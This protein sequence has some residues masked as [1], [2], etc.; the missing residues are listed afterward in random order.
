MLSARVWFCW[1]HTFGI[2]ISNY[3]MKCWKVTTVHSNSILNSSTF[4]NH[5]RCYS[6]TPQPYNTT[7]YNLHKLFPMY[8]SE[9]SPSMISSSQHALSLSDLNF[10]IKSTSSETNMQTKKQKRLASKFSCLSIVTKHTVSLVEEKTPHE[11]KLVPKLSSGEIIIRIS[12]DPIHDIQTLN[13]NSTHTV[14]GSGKIN[15][16][17]L[18]AIIYNWNSTLDCLQFESKLLPSSSLT[19]IFVKMSNLLTNPNSECYIGGGSQSDI[20]KGHKNT[21]SFNNGKLLHVCLVSRSAIESLASIQN[22]LCKEMIELAMSQY[23][24]SK[25]NTKKEYPRVFKTKNY[26]LAF[27]MDDTLFKRFGIK[28]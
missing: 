26:E 17:R 10:P 3:G 20:Q 4:P 5:H 9:N 15:H 16:Y 19:Q 14:K 23:S 8:R 24:S 2:R 18:H 13:R 1:H 7:I 27:K 12:N 28:L 11:V 21:P 25:E 22:P 6:S